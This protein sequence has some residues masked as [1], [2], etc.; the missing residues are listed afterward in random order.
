MATHM[1]TITS[2]LHSEWLNS[3]RS[4]H[5]ISS[6]RRVL[7]ITYNQCDEDSLE[8]SRWLGDCQ[9]GTISGS[10]LLSI[11]R[12]DNLSPGYLDFI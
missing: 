7:Q 8:E 12:S 11:P 9:S 10:L 5:S 1:S 6:E 2:W 4:L 3:H